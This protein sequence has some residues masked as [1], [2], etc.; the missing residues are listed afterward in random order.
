MGIIVPIAICVI[1]PVCVVAL[2]THTVTNGD[3]RRAQVLI[4]ALE[5]NNEIDT[6]KLAEAMARQ[7]RSPREI[8]NLRLLRG[9]IFACL[10][11]A[12][13][14]IAGITTTLPDDYSDLMLTLV[15]GSGI[16]LAVGIAYLVVWAITRKQAQ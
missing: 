15:F 12:C 16:G 2:I 3:N 10:G 7:N 13:A 9:C 6:S 1:L 14:V 5:S 11:L 8:L 4:K